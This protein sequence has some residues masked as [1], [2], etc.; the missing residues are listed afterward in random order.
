MGEIRITVLAYKL[1]NII[2]PAFPLD[3]TYFQVSQFPAHHSKFKEHQRA[4]QRVNENP[5]RVPPSVSQGAKARQLGHP[6]NTKRVSGRP[7]SAPINP[8]VTNTPK[9]GAKRILIWPPV[10]FHN[11]LAFTQAYLGIFWWKISHYKMKYGLYFMPFYL[12]VLSG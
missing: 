8:Q 3:L 2:C 11:P 5:P 4:K 12:I 9:C 1:I 7:N 10:I 6:H